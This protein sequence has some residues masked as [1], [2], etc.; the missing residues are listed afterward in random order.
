[1]HD[2]QEILAQ[3]RMDEKTN[4]IPIAQQM[5]LCPSGAGRVSP[6]DALHTQVDFVMLIRHGQGDV[7]LTVK[8]HQPTIHQEL[9]QRRRVH[10]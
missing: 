1:M 7:V 2:T 9:H 4:E 8:A 3:V 6:A 10:D 5:L